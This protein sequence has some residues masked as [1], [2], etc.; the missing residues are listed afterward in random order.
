MTDWRTQRSAEAEALEARRE[1][2]RHALLVA[3]AVQHARGGA[4]RLEQQAGELQVGV[5]LDDVQPLDVEARPARALV[6]VA[7]VRAGR[8]ALRALAGR[9]AAQPTPPLHHGLAPRYHHRLRHAPHRVVGFGALGA[10]GPE[11]QRRVV[12]K[13]EVPRVLEHHLP[14]WR[15]R[16]VVKVA[17]VGLRRGAVCA[18]PAADD[19][20]GERPLHAAAVPLPLQV[21][22]ASNGGGAARPQGRVHRVVDGVDQAER[23]DPVVVD[24]RQRGQLPAAAVPAQIHALRVGALPQRG[25]RLRPVDQLPDHLHAQHVVQAVA[26]RLR[27]VVLEHHVP[28]AGEAAGVGGVVLRGYKE[29]AGD[30][31]QREGRVVALRDGALGV[32]DVDAQAALVAHALREAAAAGVL[33]PRQPRGLEGPGGGVVR[34]RHAAAAAAG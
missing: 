2:R 31:G 10:E 22:Q 27:L 32:G 11:E 26:H 6:R 14:R 8:A 28:P 3:A 12:H 19:C 21:P 4:L 30:D 24:G 20:H 25:V 23:G 15:G 1:L 33:Q 13:L 9:T 17:V 16:G 18:Q 29:A 5:A 34:H 7:L